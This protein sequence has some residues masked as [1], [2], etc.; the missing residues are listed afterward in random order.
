MS[1]DFVINA[2][3]DRFSSRLAILINEYRQDRDAPLQQLFVEV[4][5]L[6]EIYCMDNCWK[7]YCKQLKKIGQKA[8]LKY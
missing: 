3:W 4:A 1:E 8:G 2:K 6:T 7:A 5:E